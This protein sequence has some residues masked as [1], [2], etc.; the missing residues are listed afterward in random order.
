MIRKLTFFL[1]NLAV[2][3]TP[4]IFTSV[5]EE[6]FEFSKMLMIYFFTT[7]IAFL[8]ITQIIIDKK[9][10]LKQNLLNLPIVLFLLSQL[11]SA[12]FSIHPRTSFFGYYTRFHGG[13]LSSI[14][15]SF[16][17]FAIVNNFNQ[18]QV[19][20]LIKSALIASIIVSVYAIPEKFGVSPSCVLLRQRFDV[21]CWVQDVQSRVFATFGQPNWLAAYLATLFPFSLYYFFLQEKSAKFLSNKTQKLFWLFGSILIFIATIFTQSRSGIL[22]ITVS[23]VLFLVFKYKKMAVK[24]FSKLFEQKQKIILILLGFFLVTTLVFIN[25][26]LFSSPILGNNK[27]VGLIKE[28]SFSQQLFVNNSSDQGVLITPSEDIRLVVWKGAIK[29]WQRYPVF[30]SGPETF[31][32]SY[33]LDRPLEHNALSEWDFLY[34]KAHNELLNTLANTGVVGLISYLIVQIVSIVLAIQIMR[35][36]S[37]NQQKQTEVFVIILSILSINITNFFGFSTVMIGVLNYLLFAYLAILSCPRTIKKPKFN[38][39]PTLL[40]L[41]T[42]I[43][44]SLITIHLLVSITSIWQADYFFTKGKILIQASEYQSGVDYLQKAIL[45]S[46]KEALFYDELA[47]TYA[48]IAVEFLQLDNLELAK[49]FTDLAIKT[50]NKTL[51]LNSVH[52]NFYQTRAS[53][54][55]KLALVDISYLENAR[56]TLLTAQKIAPTHPKLIFHQGK[57]EL[58][59]G[60]QEEAIVTI[61]KAIKLKPNY[62]EARYKL[63][64]IF[65]E[66]GDCLQAKEQYKYILQ[67]IIPNDQNLKQKIN[68]LEC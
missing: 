21:N 58:S 59:M 45:L 25:F 40:Q 62:H 66:N 39:K 63:G 34:N 52:L 4:F 57:I 27:I 17:F 11:I 29:I 68:L 53:I 20:T 10:E 22:A 36:H 67:N 42:L 2:V 44:L 9:I 18:K 61:K 12:V 47:N 5:N 46:P 16:L 1:T 19:R 15:Y 65:E 13:S 60:K 28:N 31:A 56:E 51:E 64:Q 43:C 30:G 14:A 48:S 26:P 35:K 23:A 6:L 32:Y 33:Y 41:L 55:S 24:I 37:N 38:Q 8:W 7:L 50:S 54:F 49:E 3:I